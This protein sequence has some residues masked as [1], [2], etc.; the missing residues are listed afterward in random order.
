[1]GARLTFAGII[2]TLLACSLA[3]SVAAAGPAVSLTPS[4]GPPT[5]SVA[6]QGT[7]FGASEVVALAFDLQQIGTAST[8]S[9]G[10]F[11]AKIKIPKAALPGLH[12]IHAT[13]QTSGLSAQAPF[14][15]RTDWTRFRYDQNH[16]GVQPFENVL[17]P[18]N[19]PLLQLGWQAQLGKLVDYSSPAVVNGVV[20][21]GSSDGRLWAYPAGGCGHDIC[22]A[23]LWTSTDLAQIV[24]SPTVANGL[25]YVGSQ[26]SFDS[27]DGKLDVFDANG[28][29][30]AI[31]A[32][33][34]QGDAGPESILQS[35]PAVVGGR[36]YVG[37]FDGKLYVFDAGGCGKVLC[38]PLWTGAT[39][40]HIESSPTVSGQT[41]LIG[42]NDGSL[43][44]FPAAG[45]GKNTCQPLWTGATGEPI[46]DSSPAVSKGTVYIGSA[47]HLSAFPAGGCGF[48][49]CQPLWQG[50][51]QS[52]FVNGS[53]AVYKGRVYIGLEFGVGV[54][55]AAGCGQPNCAPS[56][57]DFGTGTQA[58]VLSS[59]TVANGVVY[60]G[61][62][63]GEVLAWK[64]GPCG[65]FVCNQ[66]WSFLTQD[67]IVNS[68]P[69][70]V[71]GTLYIGGSNKFAPESSAGRLYVFSLP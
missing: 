11:S 6:V 63:N 9:S 66:I 24:D 13:G 5:T 58:D 1:V 29:G 22:T 42:S 14:T 47:Q 10:A 36:V 53:P 15:V 67:P 69:T 41:V 68:S 3:G 35:A 30:H 39:G 61:K 65:Q 56:W 62:M 55:R 64:A 19:V 17:S 25:V 31:C 33:I 43:Y 27:N 71:N 57:L 54:F 38:Q 45:C 49:T 21:I 8:N 12:A 16:T 4:V 28:C 26:T 20:Y 44:A 18:A 40:G 51:H 60:A 52:D 50:S 70:V 59:P 46:Y 32:P 23:P 34:W 7:G 37:S 48:P 2:G